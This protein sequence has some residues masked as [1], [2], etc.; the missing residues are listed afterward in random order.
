MIY[1]INCTENWENTLEDIETKNVTKFASEAG[2]YTYL[3]Y[4]YMYRERYIER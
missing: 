2:S 4:A 3:G 1:L